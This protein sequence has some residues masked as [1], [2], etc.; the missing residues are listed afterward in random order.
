M[1]GQCYGIMVRRALI[2]AAVIAT[3]LAC[4]GKAQDLDQYRRFREAR[5]AE[6][7][8]ANPRMEQQIADVKSGT[9][10]LLAAAPAKLGAVDAPPTIWRV[11]STLPF[12]YDIPVAP[13]MV[14]VPAGEASLGS[15]AGTAGRRASDTP[16][17]RVRI[18]YA[19]AVGMFPVTFAEYSLYT[20]E[21]GR[22]TKGGCALPGAKASSTRDW[23]NPGFAQ[24]FRSPAVC[25][26]V[27]DAQGYAD[28]ISQKTGQ[29]YRLLSEAEYEYATRSGTSTAF[30]WGDDRAA[31]C[32]L[33][34]VTDSGPAG[35]H[36]LKQPQICHGGTRFT[37]ELGSTKPNA[38]GLYDMAGNVASWTADCRGSPSPGPAGSGLP[39][40]DANLCR[41]RVIKGASWAT[42]DPRSAARQFAPDGATSADLGFRLARDL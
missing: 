36:S 17:H 42:S 30:W 31:G 28:W 15:S 7:H 12:I 20:A 35:S 39:D 8:T 34:N 2:G 3:C 32:A 14:I 38:F 23:R 16:R 37:A 22:V 13:R 10:A 40:R 1:R 41:H 11:A 33:T 25:I 21:T 9:A 19:F 5:F 24:T 29:H 26:G 18:A 4:V 27:S 6:V